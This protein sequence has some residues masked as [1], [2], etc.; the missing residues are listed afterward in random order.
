MCCLAFRQWSME[1][2]YF[3]ATNRNLYAMEAATGEIIWQY[4]TEYNRDPDIY[5]QYSVP[6]GVPF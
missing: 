2:L 4:E 1:V 6:G 3:G 5:P